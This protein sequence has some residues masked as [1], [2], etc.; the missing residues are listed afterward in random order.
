MANKKIEMSE[1]LYKVI[2]EENVMVEARDGVKI[3]ID[4]Y[5][6][7][8]EGT[9]P[10]LIAMSPY[11][12][13]SQ[14]Y[15]ETP[16]M[17]FGKSIF[18]A[19]CESGDPF[20]FAKRGYAFII[21][22]HRGTGD[23]EGAMV[24]IMAPQEGED[25]YD[26]IE[27]M[28]KQPWCSGKVG[29]AGICY[30]S[31]TQMQ[32]AVTQPPHLTCIA[33]WEIYGDDLYN[34]AMYDGGVLSLFWYGLYTG[35]YP[36][37]CGLAIKNIKSWMIENTLPDELK[38]I[39]D[40]ACEDPRLRQ[41]PYLYHL[42]KYP[43]KNPIL[44]DMMLNPN[45]GPF[46]RCRSFSDKLDKIN[47][48]A[49]VGGPC[50]SFFGL[51]QINV[52]NSL[53]VPKKLRLYKDMGTRPWKDD[54]DELLRWYD[55]WLKGIETGIMDEP[56]VRFLTGGVE[57]W[58]TSKEFPCETTKY[59]NFYF[60]SLGNLSTQPEL[61]NTYP[62]SFM[63]APLTV[64]EERSKVTYISMPMPEDMMVVGAVKVKFYASIDHTNTT[65][66]VELREEGS[67]ALAPLAGGWLN[68]AHRNID[69]AR[70]TAWEVVHDH[71]KDVPIVPGEINEYVVQ[72][73]P[74]SYVFKAGTRLK[75]EIS[76]IDVPV[77]P[78]TY[79]IMW[80]MCECETITHKIYRDETHQSYVSLPVVPLK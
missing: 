11:G 19:S 24:G 14:V 62:D 26:I 58:H 20:Y 29:T 10:G 32:I 15:P 54:H 34:H 40:K 30:F 38:K 60:N 67:D 35:T 43:E 71:T 17:P 28:A 3:A 4:I 77:D 76:N 9:F 65:W 27:W 55:Y 78:E 6:P 59:T 70:S 25:G 69:E 37:R 42:L 73:R 63:Q 80:H 21:A 44:F 74:C 52:W 33:P 68:A 57:T 5:R 36:A 7:D 50:F 8:A 51:P 49:Y 53:K 75:I 48:P 22:D 41:Y 39:V 64:T 56:D 13:I 46:Y 18:E 23:S 2:R 31:N 66:R 12:K 16:P 79:D 45:D 1:P 61:H 72:L 47:V